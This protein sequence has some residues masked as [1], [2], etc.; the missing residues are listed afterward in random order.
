[1][2]PA[3]E[4]VYI[5][6]PMKLHPLARSAGFAMGIAALGF[7]SACGGNTSTGGG[8]G[9][10]GD[11]GQGGT[12][13][14]PPDAVVVEELGERTYSAVLPNGYDP[15][16]PA[17]LVV[18]LHGYTDISSNPDVPLPPEAMDAYFGLSDVTRQ[19]GA[20]L[21]MPLGSEDNLFGKYFWNA[22]DVCCDINNQDTNDIGYLHAVVTDLEAQYAIDPKRIFVVGHSNGGFMANR[23]AC[24]SAGRFAGIVSLAGMPFLDPADCLAS[25]P[26]AMLHVHGDADE[27]VPYAGGEPYGIKY[28]DD[29]PGAVAAADLWADKN[30]CASYSE[31]DPIDLDVELAGAE[32]TRRVYE[33]CEAN[34][35]TELW[36]IQGGAHSPA[37]A[38][39][40]WSSRIVDFLLAHPKP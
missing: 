7:V 21:A 34:G 39:P 19:K 29:A 12:D 1:M 8:S 14:R 5:F 40:D 33:G 3:R 13:V 22:T 24:D 36:T 32:T 20:I 35:A 27:V 11:G 10:G 17:P 23:L 26:I 18:M 25:A 38:K 6:P 28:L 9:G 30:H 16:V 4:L 15:T 31:A 2:E 37:F